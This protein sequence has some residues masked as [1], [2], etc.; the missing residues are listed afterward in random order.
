MQRPRWHWSAAVGAVKEEPLD[1]ASYVVPGAAPA[2][3]A[4]DVPSE[5]EAARWLCDL[6]N[7]A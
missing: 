4:K 6:R 3:N 7:G 5:A 1:P 2:I